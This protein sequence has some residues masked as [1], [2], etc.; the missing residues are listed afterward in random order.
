M[1]IRVHVSLK[2]GVLDPQGRAVH[3][4]LEGLGFAG[5]DDVRVGRMIELDV[6]NDTSDDALTE[7][8]EKLL[9]NTVIENY[10][11]EKVG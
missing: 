4:A 10:R 5:V 3:H 8:C 7:M 2:P 1:K 6:A 11:I 9:A